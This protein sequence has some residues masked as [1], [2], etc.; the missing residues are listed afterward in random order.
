[1]VKTP[2]CAPGVVL[3]T[4]TS[5]F[6]NDD[7]VNLIITFETF[8]QVADNLQKSKKLFRALDN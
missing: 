5:I 6:F 7:S 2:T 8:S 1:M 4:S 3:E